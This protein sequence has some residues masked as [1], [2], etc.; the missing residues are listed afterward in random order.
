M[1]SF[2]VPIGQGTP[3]LY[4]R[5]D[6]KIEVN[7]QTGCHTWTGAYS[8]KRRGRRPVIQLGGRGSRV[9]L[10]DAAAAATL[11]GAAAEPGA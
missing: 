3:T 10:G 4:A 7:P 9:V 5:V 1:I 8:R 11:Q 6:A 2:P